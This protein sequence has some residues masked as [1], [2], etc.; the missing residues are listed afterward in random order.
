LITCADNDWTGTELAFEIII[1]S[2]GLQTLRF[3]HRG[4]QNT[5]DHFRI[6]SLL[7]GFIYSKDEVIVRNEIRSSLHR[8]HILY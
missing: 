7:L 3:E 4:W 8:I 2:K 1:K 5:N 6:T